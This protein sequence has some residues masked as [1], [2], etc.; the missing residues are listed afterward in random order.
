MSSDSNHTVLYD[1]KIRTLFN[2]ART[3]QTL[4]LDLHTLAD[5]QVCEFVL[6][7]SACVRERMKMCAY[8][9]GQTYVGSRHG[10]PDLCLDLKAHNCMV[11]WSLKFFE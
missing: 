9:S 1:G 5:M 10:G 4:Q 2:F 7:V 11:E 3:T 6:K 8:S